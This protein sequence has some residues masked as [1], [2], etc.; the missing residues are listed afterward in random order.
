MRGYTIID[1]EHIDGHIR[2][3]RIRPTNIKLT[4]RSVFFSLANTAWINQFDQDY[5]R[6]GLQAR[7]GPTIKY[8]AE[9][10]IK[11][12]DEAITRDSGEYVIS[13]LARKT[14]VEEMNYLDIPLAELIK[15]KV[16]GNHGFDFYS[17]NDNPNILFGEAKYNARHNAYPESFEQIAR[18]EQ[19]KRDASDLLEIDRFCCEPSKRNF[20]KGQKGF[21][22]AFASKKTSTAHLIKNIK[23]NK[24]FKCLTRFSELICVAVDV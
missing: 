5:V 14:V 10:I 20:S 3:I 24:D 19:E 4:L 21:I 9:R 16:A 6:D 7:V 23:N 8:I 17:K 15:E 2:F 22:A 1:R 12:E 11:S 13:E 18:F